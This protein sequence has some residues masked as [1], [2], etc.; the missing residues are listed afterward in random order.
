MKYLTLIVAMSL[1]LFV[2]GA[3]AWHFSGLFGNSSTSEDGS[4]ASTDIDWDERQQDFDV[5]SP[6]ANH[7][8]ICGRRYVRLARIVGGGIASYGEWPWQVAH[9][10]FKSCRCRVLK[11]ILEQTSG[12]TGR[13]VSGLAHQTNFTNPKCFVSL[14]FEYF[15]QIKVLH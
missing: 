8:D 15:F 12:Q 11:I 9:S 10:N 2:L 14:L 3:E 1:G 13:Y 6:E 4:S 5:L 7:K